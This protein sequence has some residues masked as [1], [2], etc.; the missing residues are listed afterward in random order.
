VKK[1]KK[2]SLGTY[3]VI[4]LESARSRHAFVHELLSREVDPAAPKAA[5]GK[6]AFAAMMR[7]WEIA[8]GCAS[9]LS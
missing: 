3:P 9:A 1:Y 6:S 8:H 4:T 5:L 7:V 2:L